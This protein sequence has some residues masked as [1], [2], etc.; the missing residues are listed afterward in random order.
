MDIETQVGRFDFERPHATSIRLHQ[1]AKRRGLQTL[2]LAVTKSL[3]MLRQRTL[4]VAPHVYWCT[5]R[6]ATK[7]R[8]ISVPVNVGLSFTD[9]ED[10][11]IQA[12]KWLPS[13]VWL[14]GVFTKDF[15]PPQPFIEVKCSRY[16]LDKPSALPL[17]N[18][19]GDYKES[20]LAAENASDTL[21][22]YTQNKSVFFWPKTTFKNLT[23]QTH[24]D[25]RN[26]RYDYR[27]LL[28]CWVFCIADR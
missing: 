18:A 2:L 11:V 19:V 25:N 4:F 1:A 21:Y 7:T 9:D 23:K 15:A 6:Y 5:R 14:L 16:L 20:V 24:H 10:E 22:H 27:W 26:I 17:Q 12:C 3:K 8:R 28:L 13:V